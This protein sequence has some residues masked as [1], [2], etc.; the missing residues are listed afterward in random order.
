MLAKVAFPTANV[1]HLNLD[2][3][4]YSANQE[5]ITD[6]D[7]IKSRYSWSHHS[8]GR[9]RDYSHSLQPRHKLYSWGYS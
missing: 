9:Y 5:G 6:V 3:T 4:Q 1:H 8:T 2:I 7:Y